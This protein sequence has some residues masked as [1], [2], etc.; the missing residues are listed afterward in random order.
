LRPDQ[1][2][3]PRLLGIRSRLFL[4]WWIEVSYAAAEE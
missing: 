2:P 3:R 1:H 4:H